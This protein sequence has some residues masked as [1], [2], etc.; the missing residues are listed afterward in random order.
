MRGANRVSFLFSQSVPD[1]VL[2]LESTFAREG[3]FVFP[4]PFTYQ[5]VHSQ[6]EAVEA[7][8]R[9]A[10]DAR[11]LAGG[12]SLIP[13]MRYRLARP[14]MLVDINPIGDLAIL[15]ESDGVLRVGAM[16]RDVAIER[17]PL[18]QARYAAIADAAPLIADP[19]VRQSGTLLGSLCHNDPSGDWPVVALATRASIVACSKGGARTI[20]I[21][22]FL[23]DSFTTALK[24]GELAIEVRFP[25]PPARTSGAFVKLERKAGDYA[26]ASAAVQLSLAPD[27]KVAQAGIAIGA[28]GACALR[29]PEAEQLFIGAVPTSGMIRAAM[30]LA[31]AAADPAADKRGSAEYKRDMAGVLAG[32]ALQKTFKRLGVGGLQ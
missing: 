23:V 22:E 2:Q 15:E 28:V 17:S 11:V 13:A 24:D 27:G 19:I 5:R 3:I 8:A 9:C 20:P 16:A 30:D 7:L 21:D 10:P 12:Q 32:R 31:R 1:A 25:A 6:D 26:T 4:A 18:I 14:A 29:V